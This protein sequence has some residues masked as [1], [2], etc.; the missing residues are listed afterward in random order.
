MKWALFFEAEGAFYGPKLDIQ[1]KA[2]LGKEETL[3]TISLT[4][5][6]Q[7]ASTLNTSELMVKNIA[8]LWSTIRIIST[9]ERFTAI[10]IE[11]YKGAFPPGLRHTG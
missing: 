7:N 2:A 5:C 10:L 9:M 1:V 3:S 6:S 4:S 8:Q 11:N